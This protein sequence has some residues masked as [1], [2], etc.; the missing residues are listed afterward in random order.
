MAKRTISF[1]PSDWAAA[2][3]ALRAFSPTRISQP[4]PQ[5]GGEWRV[6]IEGELVPDGPSPARIEVDAAAQPD[7]SIARVYRIVAA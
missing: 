3:A 4:I 7:G 5:I 2:L 6:I 1:R